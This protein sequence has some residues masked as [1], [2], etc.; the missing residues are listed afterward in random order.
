MAR[1]MHDSTAEYE[2]AEKARLRKVRA[3][4]RSARHALSWYFEAAERMQS[5]AGRSPRGELDK[6][7]C[8]VVVRVDGGVGG[9]L[10]DTLATISTIGSALEA[11]KRHESKWAYVLTAVIRDG[12]KQSEVAAKFRT[13]QPTVSGWM[14]KGEAFIA[15]VLVAAELI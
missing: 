3:R 5:P 2:R 4:F 1:R 7:G 12:H 14:G 6:N 9:S 8:M 10:D 15:G 11:L 13:T